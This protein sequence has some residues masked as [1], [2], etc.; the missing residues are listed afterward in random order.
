MDDSEGISAGIANE[1]A[2]AK[3]KSES[4]ARIALDVVRQR[5]DQLNQLLLK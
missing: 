3:A 2:K 4:D 1:R 5:I